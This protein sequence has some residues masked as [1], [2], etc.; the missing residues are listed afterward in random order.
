MTDYSTKLCCHLEYKLPLQHTY[1]TRLLQQP[2]K[3]AFA[4]THTHTHTHYITVR[5]FS[6]FG[7]KSRD[8]FVTFPW[9]IFSLWPQ[10]E[11][12]GL[13][14]GGGRGPGGDRS[15]GT[16]SMR[17]AVNEFDEKRVETFFSRSYFIH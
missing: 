1:Y 9:E 16:P 13:A 6:H 11:W 14:I 3:V 5:I 8:T 7:R 12:L 15:P 10:D 17:A 2:V 4:H